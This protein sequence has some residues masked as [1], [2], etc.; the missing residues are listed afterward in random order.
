L[1]NLREDF[2]NVA[3]E[4][5]TTAGRDFFQQ[6]SQFLEEWG[7]SLPILAAAARLTF[8]PFE[9]IARQAPGL[10]RL[11]REQTEKRR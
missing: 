10:D 2:G 8:V 6:H 7:F 3:D 5:Q 1:F 9:L 11:P 4:D